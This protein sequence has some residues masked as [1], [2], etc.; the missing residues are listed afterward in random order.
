MSDSSKHFK[1][2]L[3]VAEQNAIED[4][5]SQ[6]PE[7]LL[8]ILEDWAIQQT[9]YSPALNGRKFSDIELLTRLKALLDSNIEHEQEKL[10]KGGNVTCLRFE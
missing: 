2:S 10:E 7:K 8:A 1:K 4:M 6:N 5:C 3:S 9:Y